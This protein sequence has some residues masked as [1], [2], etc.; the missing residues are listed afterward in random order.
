MLN[1]VIHFAVVVNVALI[2]LVVCLST[3]I[4]IQGQRLKDYKSKTEKMQLEI[5]WYEKKNS[6]QQAGEI[7]PGNRS[8]VA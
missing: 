1:Q 2:M 4:T 8:L 7:L 6:S 3:Y 5:R